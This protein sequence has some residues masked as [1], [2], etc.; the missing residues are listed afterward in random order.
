MNEWLHQRLRANQA[1]GANAHAA[2]RSVKTIMTINAV[3][4]IYRLHRTTG[5]AR[6]PCNSGPLCR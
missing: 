1:M 2:N 3:D 5:A 4:P 6:F